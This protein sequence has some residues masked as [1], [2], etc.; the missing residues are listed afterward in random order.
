[1]VTYDV[2]SPAGYFIKQVSLHVP[3]DGEKDIVYFVGNLIVI[4]KG[5]NDLL[6]ADVYPE[7]DK[8]EIICYSTQ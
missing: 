7:A 8:L 2:F 1:M 4:V 3:G 5:Q 6:A